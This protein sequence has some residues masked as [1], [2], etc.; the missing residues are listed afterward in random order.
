MSFADQIVAFRSAT[1]I[2]A[3]HGGGL[4]NIIF[5]RAGTAVIEFQLPQTGIMYWHIAVMQRLR[6]LAYVPRTFNATTLNYLIQP[7]RLIAAIDVVAGF[8]P[9]DPSALAH[10]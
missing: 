7:D 2:I 9:L 1:I 8:S 5:C 3:P 6:Y 10:I 4:T